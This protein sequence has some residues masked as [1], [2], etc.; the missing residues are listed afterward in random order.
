MTFLFTKVVK[1]SQDAFCLA[2]LWHCSLGQLIWGHLLIHKN[3]ETLCFS[4]PGE[5][6]KFRFYQESLMEFE[7]R[8][9]PHLSRLH[10]LPKSIAKSSLKPDT[11]GL[12]V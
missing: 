12:S 5:F 4:I 8:L 6:R 2:W 1:S 9:D 3:P 11:A 10:L 7:G